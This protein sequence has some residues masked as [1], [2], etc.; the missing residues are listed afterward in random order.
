MS[1]FSKIKTNIS[2]L[3]MLKKTLND[4]N[5]DYSLDTTNHILVFKSNI[6]VKPLF[7]FS[8]D[9]NQY[10]LI[11]DFN[12]WNLNISSDY[13]LEKLIQQYALNIITNESIISGFDLKTSI[14]MQDGSLKLIIQ[15]WNN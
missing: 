15:K 7:S 4:L 9:G 11:A 6:K 14:K 5:F 10:N 1:H 3:D 2:D 12:L 13:F 8:W